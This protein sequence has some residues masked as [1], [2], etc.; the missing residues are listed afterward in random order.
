VA[1]EVIGAGFGRTGTLS[2]KTAL[3]ELGF[4]PCEH[5]TVLFQDPARIALWDE[6]ARAKEAGQPFAWE[7]LF[8]GYRATVDWPGA[9][10][11]RELL[12]AYPEAKV[13]LTV[14]D[15]DRW[16]D[17]ARGTIYR[18]HALR[19]GAEGG[20]A[21]R[22]GSV[23]FV[24]LG[25]LVPR[26]RRGGEM[27][28]RIVWRGTFDDRFLDREHALAVFRRHVD[29]VEAAVPPEQLLVY[30]VKQGWGPLCRFL[31]VPVPAG[32]FPHVNDAADFQRTIRRRFLAPVV[33]AAG[34]IAAVL[35]L[36]IVW[37]RRARLGRGG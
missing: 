4:A 25:T 18:P 27:V 6:A 7:R 31:G 11:W 30:E 32:P 14:R 17:S 5:M 1:L 24:L 26:A 3:E 34:G 36:A 9:W 28:E 16:Y 12:A 8:A 13:I 19:K 10:F 15:P 22:L 29:E 35:A 37:T 33:A 20:P 21:A 2:L 23:L